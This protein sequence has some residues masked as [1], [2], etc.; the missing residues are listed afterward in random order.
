MQRFNAQCLQDLPYSPHFKKISQHFFRAWCVV[1]IE[2]GKKFTTPY[3]EI[4][5]W[6]NNE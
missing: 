4:S 6:Y 3:P 1:N 5:E 2:K